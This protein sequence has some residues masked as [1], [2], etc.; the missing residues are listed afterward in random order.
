[1]NFFPGQGKVKEFVHRQGNLE[2]TWQVRELE[3]KL[4]RLPVFR[5]FVYSVQEVKGCTPSCRGVL[6]N[7]KEFAPYKFEVIQLTPLK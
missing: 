7:R 6:L 2:R 4:L 5:K 1:M 3:N